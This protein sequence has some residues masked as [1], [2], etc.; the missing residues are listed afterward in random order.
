MAGLGWT[1]ILIVLAV[2][3]LLFGSAKLPQLARSLGKSARILKAETKGLR[4]DD[5][6]AAKPQAAPPQQPPA[7]PQQQQYAPPPQGQ[8]PSGQPIQ[9]VPVDPNQARNAH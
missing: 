8:L 3:M 1:E 2:I 4:E 5:D 9:G 6:E 7:Q